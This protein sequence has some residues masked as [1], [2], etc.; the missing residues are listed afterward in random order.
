MLQKELHHFHHVLFSILFLKVR[1]K[2][3]KIPDGFAYLLFTESC[4]S[5]LRNSDRLGLLITEMF[6]ISIHD[7]FGKVKAAVSGST[8]KHLVV[9]YLIIILRT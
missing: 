4:E 1:F 2:G 5:N 8:W 7:L 9:F 3:R 6:L